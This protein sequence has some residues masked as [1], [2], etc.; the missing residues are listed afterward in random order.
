MNIENMRASTNILFNLLFI[1]K[2]NDI[3]EAMQHPY[4]AKIREEEGRIGGRERE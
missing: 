1:T 3:Q 2:K 4:F